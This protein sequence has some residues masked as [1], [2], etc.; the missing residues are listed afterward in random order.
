MN[1]FGEAIG[2]AIAGLSH[3]QYNMHS[4]HN[5]EWFQKLL[6][7]VCLLFGCL[8]LYPFALPKIAGNLLRLLYF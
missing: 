6:R 2:G 8:L 3:A 5:V 1:T 4:D 7:L